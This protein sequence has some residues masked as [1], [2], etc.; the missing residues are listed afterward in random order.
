MPARIHFVSTSTPHITHKN[1]CSIDHRT[2][3]NEINAQFSNNRTKSVSFCHHYFLQQYAHNYHLQK[4]DNARNLEALRTLSESSV[5]SNKLLKE[6]MGRLN[7]VEK[8][9]GVEITTA[10]ELERLVEN[11]YE[12][13]E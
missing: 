8:E 9:A 13:K 11:M 1:A 7:W 12:A 4:S 6:A 10:E 2:T 3:E 5:E